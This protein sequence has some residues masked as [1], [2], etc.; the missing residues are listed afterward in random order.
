MGEIFSL[1]PLARESDH[2]TAGRTAWDACV[3]HASRLV[4]S[5]IPL[6]RLERSGAAA[7]IL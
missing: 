1:P 6:A 3:T 2:P 7:K 5:A 4:E